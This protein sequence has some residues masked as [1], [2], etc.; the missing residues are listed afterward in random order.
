MYS[1][2]SIVYFCLVGKLV[3]SPKRSLFFVKNWLMEG[4]KEE[5]ALSRDKESTTMKKCCEVFALVA[6][7]GVAWMLLLL[8]VIFYYLPDEIYNNMVSFLVE[9]IAIIHLQW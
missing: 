3:I 9:V 5:D 1:T 6:T 4:Q 8:P 2:A 7:V